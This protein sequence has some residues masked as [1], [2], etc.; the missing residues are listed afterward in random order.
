MASKADTEAVTEKDCTSFN[1]LFE[2]KISRCPFCG[3]VET[4]IFFT[5][6]DGDFYVRVECNECHAS[7]ARFFIAD[8]KKKREAVAKAV[9]AWNRRDKRTCKQLCGVIDV[10]K[11]GVQKKPTARKKGGTNAKGAKSCRTL[12]II[13][14]KDERIEL[15]G[16]ER[17]DDEGYLKCDGCTAARWKSKCVV[18]CETD[19]KGCPCKIG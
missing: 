12:T 13:R 16:D 3:S 9:K 5:C 1:G 8:V 2:G 11:Y 4:E 6:E 18:Q 14:H 7:S 10:R 19:K 15:R 17:L